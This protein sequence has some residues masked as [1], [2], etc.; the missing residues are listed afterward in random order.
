[1]TEIR[2]V[3]REQFQ[4]GDR[5][6]R[7]AWGSYR[8]ALRDALIPLS[9]EEVDLVKRAGGIDWIAE[10]ETADLRAL[11]YWERGHRLK[12]V[13]RARVV[14]EL[15]KRHATIPE[16]G[17]MVPGLRGARAALKAEDAKRQT[18]VLRVIR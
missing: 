2:G 18:A 10:A 16:L 7:E 17:G 11:E 1:M 14:I 3:T 9:P 15:A 13:L 5:V 8:V 6:I 4:Q 12:T